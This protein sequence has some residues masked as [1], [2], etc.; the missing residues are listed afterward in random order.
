MPISVMNIDV[1]PP[2]SSAKVVQFIQRNVH[3]NQ[4]GFTPGMKGWYN[5]WKLITATHSID[6]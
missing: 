1:S 6:M 3:H 2:Q 4:V 5:V